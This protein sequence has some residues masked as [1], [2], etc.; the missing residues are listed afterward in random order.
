[1]PDCVYGEQVVA[2]VA[3]REGWDATERDLRDFVRQRLADYK[4]PERIL[5]LGDLPKGLPGKFNGVN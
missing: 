2:F 5:F 1:M 4:T 3:L